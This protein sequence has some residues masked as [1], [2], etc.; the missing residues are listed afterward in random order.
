MS[1]MVERIARTLAARHYAK[2][3]DKPET[4]EHVLMNVNGNWQIFAGQ[5]REVIELMREPTHQMIDAALD[6]YDRR[7]GKQGYTDSWN[8]MLGAALKGEG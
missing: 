3:F 1:E 7:G 2:R 4:D 8:A 6:D 5:V